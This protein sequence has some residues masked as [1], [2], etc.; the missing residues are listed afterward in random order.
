MDDKILRLNIYDE[1]NE[2]KKTVEAHFVEI[3]FG[4]IK[5]LLA[6]LEVDQID[7]TSELLKVLYGSWKAVTDVLSKV[8]PEMEEDD[9]D[10]VKLSELLPIVVSIL[11]G[12]FAHILSIPTDSKN[13]IAE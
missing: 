6:V 5:K 2:I 4:T 3:R 13:V 10:G 1:E 12:S 8:F 7:D 11:K 9:W